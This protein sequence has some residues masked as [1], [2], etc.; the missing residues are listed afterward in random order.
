MKFEFGFSVSVS[1]NRAT[2]LKKFESKTTD[3]TKF[4]KIFSSGAGFEIGFLRMMIERVPLPDTSPL[5]TQWIA[6]VVCLAAVAK[7][8]SEFKL[9]LDPDPMWHSDSC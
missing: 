5:Y 7:T 2:F 1:R 6:N 4:T 9:T 8:L 3:F